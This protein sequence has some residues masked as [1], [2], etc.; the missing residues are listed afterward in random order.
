M[1]V[2]VP[3]VLV[4]G[5]STPVAPT[6]RAQ[7]SGT[8]EIPPALAPLEYLIGGWKGQATPRERTAN[9][10]RG[11]G[12]EHTWAWAFQKGVPVGMT[13]DFKDGRTFASG[14]LSFDSTTKKYR[15][16]AA[17]AKTAGSG[18]PIAF[19][20]SFDATGKLLTFDQAAADP[21]GDQLRIT[22]RPNANY[23][24]YTMMIE[25]K[26][27]NIRFSPITEIGCT[28]KGES[29]AGGA[30]ANEGPKCIVTGGAATMNV[31]YQ[32]RS[33][34]VCCTGCVAEFNDNPEKYLKKAALLS[35]TQAGKPRADAPG[36]SGVSRSED[37][38]AGDVTAAPSARMAGPGA[39]KSTASSPGKAAAAGTLS[40]DP[41]AKPETSS[42]KPAATKAIN[43][44][45]SLLQIAENLEKSGKV[46]AAIKDYKQIVKDYADTPSAR[47]AASRIKALESE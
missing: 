2:F 24:R 22:F 18:A 14:K 45:A 39:A 27:S 30:T 40:D 26:E 47:K 44:A 9:K 25:R 42:S 20:G 33:F 41:K 6:A 3:A 19:V 13:V 32:G 43:R 34:P 11:W 17:R 46:E 29:L 21:K 35:S 10:F 15:L 8:R 16:D 28:R 5:W 4:L 36:S 23:L 12:E 37:D 1:I 31:S 7:E 38:F